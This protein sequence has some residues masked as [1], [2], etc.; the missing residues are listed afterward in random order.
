MRRM[1]GPIHL[2]VLLW[3]SCVIGSA[4]AAP[5]AGTVLDRPFGG[6]AQLLNAADTILAVR[7]V[8]WE[9]DS[10]LGIDAR[11]HLWRRV[12]VALQSIDTA[13]ESL[14]PIQRVCFDQVKWDAYCD[15]QVPF[16]MGRIFQQSLQVGDGTVVMLRRHDDATRHVVGVVSPRPNK[17]V[18]VRHA[19]DYGRGELAPATAQLLLAYRDATSEGEDRARVYLAE[20]ISGALYGDDEADAGMVAAM[21]D[22]WCRRATD[23]RRVTRELRILARRHH[24]AVLDM[25]RFPGELRLQATWLASAMPVKQRRVVVRELLAVRDSLDANP[26]SSRGVGIGGSREPPQSQ[27]DAIAWSWARL[28]IPREIELVMHPERVRYSDPG[29][30]ITPGDPSRNEAAILSEARRFVGERR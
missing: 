17:H 30:W 10:T 18:Q 2:G 24:G 13:M 16:Y 8:R 15:T 23:R 19:E 26:K 3:A 12:N 9:P 22:D 29:F 4:R 25:C 1:L 21:V 28:K 27:M 20:R 14:R 7:I 6:L 11:S 5:E